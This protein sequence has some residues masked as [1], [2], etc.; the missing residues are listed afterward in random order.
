MGLQ[1]GGGAAVDNVI[2]QQR[3]KACICIFKC[4]SPLRNGNGQCAFTVIDKVNIT[5]YQ[6]RF[7]MK[8]LGL[9]NQSTKKLKGNR[10]QKK[11]S[12][13]FLSAIYYLAGNF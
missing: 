6:V 12:A 10:K 7:C 13:N 3:R 9:T 4:I 2:K 1:V 11:A 8:G 5:V